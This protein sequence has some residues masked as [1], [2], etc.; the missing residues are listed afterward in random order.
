MKLQKTWGR[1]ANNLFCWY[2]V[3]VNAELHHLRSSA[4][5]LF[6]AESGLEL[7]ILFL[8]W[9]IW[10]VLLPE[11]H[12]ILEYC[13][14][15]HLG[16]KMFQDFPAWMRSHALQT[17]QDCSQWYIFQDFVQS[18]IKCLCVFFFLSPSGNSDYLAFQLEFFHNIQPAFSFPCSHPFPSPI[19][20]LTF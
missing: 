4:F 3:K 10:L 11:L 9:K 6:R 13:W 12:E 2:R 1:G 20:V 15:L 14:E 19:H 17:R 5:V 7:A 18:G 8:H 16:I